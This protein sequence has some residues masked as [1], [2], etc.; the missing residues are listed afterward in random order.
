VPP[1]KTVSEQS[2]GIHHPVARTGVQKNLTLPQ[3]KNSMSAR[4]TLLILD[5]NDPP[6]LKF[7][8]LF[9]S[10]GGSHMVF[11]FLFLTLTQVFAQTCFTPSETPCM[12]LRT[13]ETSWHNRSVGIHNVDRYRTVGKKAFRRDGAV[14]YHLSQSSWKNYFIPVAAGHGATLQLPDRTIS[15]DHGQKKYH[16][17]LI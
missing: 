11:M 6:H 2:N 16:V 17:N 3:K 9:K 14:A 10:C 8:L 12:T 5:E 4:R 15:I 1:Q 13:T 7:P